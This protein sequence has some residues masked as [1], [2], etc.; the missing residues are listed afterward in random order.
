M[1]DWLIPKVTTVEKDGGWP[2]AGV[3]GVPGV[4]SVQIL[5]KQGTE[6]QDQG[7]HYWIILFIISCHDQLTKSSPHPERYTGGAL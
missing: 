4:C 6:L 7:V 2:E 3:R 1:V 5:L